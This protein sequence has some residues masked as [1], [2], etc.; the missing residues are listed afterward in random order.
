MMLIGF[1]PVAVPA[2]RT[3]AGAPARLAS[4]VYV[5]VCPNGINAIC[6]QTSL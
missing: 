4:S 6:R 5:I 2:A 1:L 3:A